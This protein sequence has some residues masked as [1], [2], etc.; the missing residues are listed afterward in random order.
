MVSRSRSRINSD[1]I[2]PSIFL[3]VSHDPFGK[4]VPALPDHALVLA[5]AT[6]ANACEA[7]DRMP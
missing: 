4:A 1:R 2:D 6:A 5:R 3:F 7:D